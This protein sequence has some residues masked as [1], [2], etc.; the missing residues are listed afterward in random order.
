MAPP[1]GKMQKVGAVLFNE[2]VKQQESQEKGQA[3]EEKSSKDSQSEQT[4]QSEQVPKVE[5]KTI[6]AENG[7]TYLSKL[8]ENL[9]KTSFPSNTLLYLSTFYRDKFILKLELKVEGI[10]KETLEIKIDKVAPDN[11]AYQA[12]VQ[13]T[14][15]DLFLD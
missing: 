13:S 2:E 12:L 9:E 1:N 5:T 4:D 11:K 15:T 8:F 6:Q 10:T 14:N 3:K 7:G